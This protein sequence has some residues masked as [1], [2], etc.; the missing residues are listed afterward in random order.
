MASLVL[1][2]VVVSNID[3]EGSIIRKYPQTCDLAIF[4]QM[5]GV[6]CQI[7]DGKNHALF[8]ICSSP[9]KV[10]SFISS[11]IPEQMPGTNWKSL[12]LSRARLSLGWAIVVKS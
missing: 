3:V 2:N 10:I 7:L 8:S 1:R 6:S 4:N 9:F 11:Q 12:L 5:L